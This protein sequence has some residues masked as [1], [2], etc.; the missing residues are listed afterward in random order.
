MVQTH[1]GLSSIVIRFQVGTD[2]SGKPK[3]KAFPLK[4]VKAQAAMDDIWAVAQAL[5][6]L[7]TLPIDSVE[8]IDTEELTGP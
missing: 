6:G 5:A 4:G 3:R 1:P 8:R 2:A 7:Q